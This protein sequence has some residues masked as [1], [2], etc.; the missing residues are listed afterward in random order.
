MELTKRKSPRIPGFN[1]AMPNYYFITMCTHNKECIFGKPRELSVYGKIAEENLLKIPQLN[2]NMKIDKYV[3]M[4]NHIHVI[5]IVMSEKM[6]KGLNDL[7]VVIGQY[8]MS[9]TKRIR[10]VEQEKKVWQRSF[11]DHVIRNQKRYERIWQYID[12]NPQKWEEDCF[13][14]TEQKA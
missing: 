14:P 4:P 1:Y 6:E 7:S 12:N 11:H 3:V 9:V 2:P 5:I 10:E 8:K 13:Y